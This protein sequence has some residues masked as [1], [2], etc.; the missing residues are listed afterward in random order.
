MVLTPPIRE[1]PGDACIPGESLALRM[2]ARSALHAILAT[3]LR[4]V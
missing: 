2:E 4:I 1:L 3:T